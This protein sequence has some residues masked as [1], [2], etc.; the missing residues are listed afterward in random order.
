MSMSSKIIRAASQQPGRVSRFD[1][2][3]LVPGPATAAVLQAS[4]RVDAEAPAAATVLS[5]SPTASQ[6]SAAE[7]G[8]ANAEVEL[9]LRQARLKAA[10]IEKEAYEKGFSEGERAGRETGEK[11]VEAVLKQY[12]RTLEELKG[13]RRNLLTGSEREVV[14]LSLEVAKK[15]VKR[16]ACVDEELI[17]ALVRVAL[18]RLADQSVMTV[19]VNPKDCQSILH[20]RE[21]PGH[22]DSWHDGIKLV[23]DPLITRG[24]CLIET[25]SGLIDARVEEQFREIEKGFFE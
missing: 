13:L 20:H 8:H 12:A 2:G 24:G 3:V 9:I 4:Q 5:E 19:R 25:E 18:S 6:L 17:L 14:R 15:V 23:E 10:E 1:F 16:E 7:L 21:S 22:R 11:M